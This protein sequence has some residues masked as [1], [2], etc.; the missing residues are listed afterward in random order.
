M[1]K[2]NGVIKKMKVRIIIDSTVD[3][4]EQLRSRFSVVPLTVRFGAEEFIDGV[5][6]DKKAFY[7]RLAQG[8]DLPTTAQPSPAAFAERF[9]EV[10][11]AGESAVVVTIASKLSGT[12]QSAC[13]AAGEYENIFVVDSQSA[14]VGSGILAE[15]ALAC[16]ERGMEA[17]ELAAHL[18]EKSA[19]IRVIALLDSLE[20]LKRGGRISPAVAFAGGILHV[21]PVIGI[22]DGEV[23]L[24]GKARGAGRGSEL[25]KEKIRESGG[26][27]LSMPV[28]LG[29]SGT[30]DELLKKYVEENRPI[31]ESSGVEPRAELLCSVIGTHTG[32]GVVGAAYFRKK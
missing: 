27:D 6:M 11:R 12:Y 10:T 28:L 31:W 30:S 8:G 26:V 23:S 24:V 4:S 13:I 22:R 18:T 20:F 5:S 9:D 29:Y 16:A 32:P 21:K 25:L 3:V 1:P 14:A 15:Y 7:A 2:N 17:R 19:D